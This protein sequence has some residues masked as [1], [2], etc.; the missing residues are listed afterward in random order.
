[1]SVSA[2]RSRVYN[3]R[4]ITSGARAFLGYFLLMSIAC[5]FVG[6]FFWMVSSSLK[7]E[8]EIF[9]IPIRWLPEKLVW[10]NYVDVV[11]RL[12]F[13]LFVFNSFKLAL[14]STLGTL[15]SC[16]LAAY[17]FARLQFLG[18]HVLFMILLATM[19]IPGEV[20]LIPV[21]LIMKGLGLLNT[22]EALYL[23]SFFG[24]AY[25]TFLLRQ[26]FLT[27]PSELDDAA[28]I[29]GCGRFGIYLRIYLPLSKPAL[30]TLAVFRFMGAWNDLLGPVIYLNETEKFTLAVGLTY[31]R[32][33][34]STDWALLMAACV[35]AVIPIIVIY[36]LAQ[37]Y[38][39][40][41]I[42]L[43]GLKG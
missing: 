27:L 43:T 15:L 13:G 17:A 39:V 6:P 35:I 3:K 24:G 1:M 9:I 4:A 41:G 5:V 38:F 28:L 16:S 19:M 11:T 36:V 21:F 37:K 22:H 31:F 14:L 26:F 25:G 23:P 7:S 30:A 2:I 34:Y 29:D 10:R 8:P 20:T 12:P 33:Y 32:G 40:Q 18:S 42:A